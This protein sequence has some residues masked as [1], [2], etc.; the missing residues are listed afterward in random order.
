MPNTDIYHSER[1]G[2][3]DDFSY[4]IPFDVMQ[5][6]TYTIVLK[7]S[8]QYF[9]E[10]GMKVFDIALGEQIVISNLDPFQRAGSKLLPYDAFIQFEA[11]RGDIIW[12]GQKI[13]SAFK[14]KHLFVHF[15]LGEADNPKV[16]AIA[17]VLGGVEKTHK[18]SFDLYQKTLVEIQKEKALQR[19]KDESL[20]QE[21]LYDFEE[22]IDG[23]GIFNQLM[24]RT[25]LLEGLIIV[26]MIG[27]FRMLPKENKN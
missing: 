1:W 4:K 9:W 25:Y 14:N 7:F 2:D 5:D 22:R 23:Q 21:D 6:A 20:F 8:E 16:N 24:A 3:K 11:K 12:N 19:A 17:L 26:F 10:P 27:F 15:K 13:K 18:K